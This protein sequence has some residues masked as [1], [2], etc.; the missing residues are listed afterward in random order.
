MTTRDLPSWGKVFRSAE[1]DVR[2][3]KD[4]KAY[5]GFAVKDI[6]AAKTFYG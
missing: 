5:S 4:S 2:G 1:E 3:S 6:A